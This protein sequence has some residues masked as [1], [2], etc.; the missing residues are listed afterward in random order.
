MVIRIKVLKNT[1][2]NKV[3]LP[4]KIFK[5]LNL[6]KEVLY[7]FLVGQLN[8]VVLFEEHDERTENMYVPKGIFDQL[9]LLED[10]RIN[11]WREEEAVCVGPVVGIFVNTC[12]LRNFVAAKK[13]NYGVHY[14]RDGEGSNCLTFFF[15][16]YD[17][18]WIDKKIKGSLIDSNGTTRTSHW[19]P[20]PDVIYDRGASFSI[21]QKPLVRFL[22]Q[23]FKNNSRI[24]LINRLDTLA[25]PRFKNVF[26]YA[27]FLARKRDKK[28]KSS[29]QQEKN[30]INS[31][32]TR[33]LNSPVQKMTNKFKLF[34][35][36]ELTVATFI[37]IGNI[38]KML[39]QKPVFRHLELMQANN[40]KT[41]LNLFFFSI[42]DVDLIN[43]S[44]NGTYFNQE[45]GIWEQNDFSFPDVLYDRGG[46]VLGHQKIVSDYI[47]EQLE[48]TGLKKINPFYTFNKW[49]MHE[50]LYKQKKM[51]EYLP[52][53]RLYQSEDDIMAM[54]QQAKHLYLKKCDSN[55][56]K[57]IV[58]ITKEENGIYKYSIAKEKL[59]QKTVSSFSELLRRLKPFL[60]KGEVI[61]QSAINGLKVS[62]SNIDMRATIQRNGQGEVEIVAYPVRLGCPDYPITSTRTGARVFCFDEFF[63][64]YMHYSKEEITF[65]Q[66]KV[67][68]FLLESFDF[69]ENA[70]GIF[71]ELGIDFAIDIEGRIWFIECNAKPGN[72]SLYKSHSEETVKTVFTNPLEY[73]R[74]ISGEL[75]TNDPTE[76]SATEVLKEVFQEQVK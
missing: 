13:R 26:D 25:I 24:Q 16:I 57:S 12:Y 30:K 60:Q 59:V 44:I 21:N 22:R 20:L 14:V 73:A 63:E 40:E 7:Q 17:I 52:I 38:K 55:N 23:Q 50:K 53:T 34:R 8:S 74:Y 65:L 76:E 56:G 42:K 29:S 18:N 19:F 6:N 62:R 10:K 61:I 33:I 67:E 69:I 1:E 15:S 68:D 5:D 43:R 49:D 39:N 32:P 37:S 47:R 36:D 46:A 70:Y 58:K 66:I 28:K 11:I 72:D 27:K 3:L 54:F 2:E 31:E 51:R 4:K 45:T 41:K 71:G 48:I 64:Q 75:G 35:K 9:C